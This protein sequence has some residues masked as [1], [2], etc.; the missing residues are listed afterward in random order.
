MITPVILSG[1]SGTRLWPLSRT[2]YPK[3]FLPLNSDLSMLQETVARVSDLETEKVLVICNEGHRFLVAEQMRQAGVECDILLEP[4]GRNTAPAIALAA[5]KAESEGRG[6]DV[7]LV[8][9]ADH[10][11]END[12]AFRQAIAQALPEAVSGK[13]VTFGIVPSEA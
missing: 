12:A 13:L 2:M 10:V 4:V 11:I 1:G 9:A 7:L 3:Q 6:D 8:L 5:L